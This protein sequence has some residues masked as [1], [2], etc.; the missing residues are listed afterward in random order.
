MQTPERLRLL[1][2]LTVAD[3]R[4]VGPGVWNGWKGQLMRELYGATET[5][6]RGGRMSD[7]AGIARRRQEAIAYDARTAL[8]AADPEARAWA[9]SMEDA[10][11]VAFPAEEQRAHRALARRAEATGGAAAEARIRAD[12]NAAEIVVSAPDRRGLFADL[13]LAISSLGGNVVGARIFTSA[14]G[15]ALDVFYVQDASGGPFGADAERALTRL[16]EALERAGRGE[17]IGLEPRRGPDLGRAGAFA[18]SPSVAFDNDASHGATVVE[19]SGR[20]RPGLLEAL[21]RTLSE[22]DLSIQSA[23]VDNYGE[24]AVDAF[25]V[26]TAEGAKLTEARRMAAI[27]ARLTEVLTAGEA[28]S[29]RRLPKARAS[30]AR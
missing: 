4:A 29:A 2:V 17:P 19:A 7:A 10:Y 23:H 14:A 28:Q 22:S 20:D 5:I 18:I 12:R 11:F 24:R 6:F 9:T 30:V 1:L 27:R 8:V 3:I 16:A 21:A 15:Q 25:Y 26:V 13:A